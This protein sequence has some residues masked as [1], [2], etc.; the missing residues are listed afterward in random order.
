MVYRSQNYLIG[1]YVTDQQ[2]LGVDNYYTRLSKSDHPKHTNCSEKGFL[3][4]ALM[5]LDVV[6][7]LL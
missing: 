6:K 7:I 5:P 4:F 1:N 3:K 2:K